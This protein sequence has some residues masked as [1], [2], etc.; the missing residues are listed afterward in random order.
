MPY[1]TSCSF[2]G[3]IL[4]DVLDL[5]FHPHSDYFP[6]NAKKE[7]AT[8]PLTLARCTS[9]GLYQN[10]FLLTT[11]QMF[12]DEY[13]YDSSVNT[14][15][16]SHWLGLAKKLKEHI[17]GAEENAG[18][19]RFLDVGSNSGE[20]LQCYESVGCI[21][22]GI[23]PSIEPHKLAI[24]RGLRSYNEAFSAR[25][26]NKLS[27]DEYECISFTNSFPHIPDPQYT[28]ELAAKVLNQDNGI[29]CIESPS[30]QRMIQSGQY[31]QIYH[32]HMTYLDIYPLHLLCER[33][34]LFLFDYMETDFHN[35]SI[36]YFISKRGS[37]HSRSKKLEDY[38]EDMETSLPRYL[39]K[40]VDEDFRNRCLDHRKQFRRMVLDIQDAGK[41]LSFVSAPAKGNTI[42]NFCGITA[43]DA[44]FT[45]EANKLKIGR[46]MP[47]SGIE[48]IS[49]EE[50]GAHKPDYAV[51]LAWN[52]F[53][54]I[55][56]SVESSLKGAKIIHP[57]GE[58]QG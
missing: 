22:E 52:F 14:S 27:F 47:L 56:A 38:L 45:S 26:L 4:R 20:L 9:C 6:A 1:T 2:C 29:I 30:A 46:Y 5:G 12:N 16:K 49:D 3:S 34:G 57:F 43:S 33:I 58:L 40:Q 32:Q 28:L 31:D 55:K 36:C 23:E 54:S 51:I 17:D 25:S 11:E 15:A 50:L 53:N 18:E 8:Y 37:R 35:G 24:S 19:R 10:D 13:L 42:L 48:I 7:L 44:R 39:D 21:A 41:K